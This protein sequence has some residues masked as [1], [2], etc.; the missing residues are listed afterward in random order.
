MKK[1]FAAWLLTLTLLLGV[2]PALPA[3]AKDADLRQ[4]AARMVELINKE[5]KNAGLT[6]VTADNSCW[7]RP[8]M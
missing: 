5:R 6:P 8:P 7:S 3:S 4:K 2:L 1:K